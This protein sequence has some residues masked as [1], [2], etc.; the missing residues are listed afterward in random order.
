MT[1]DLKLWTNAARH[2]PWFVALFTVAVLIN[3]A[4]EVAQSP[5]YTETGS[6]LARIGN[7]FL[8]SLIDGVIVLFIFAVGWLALRDALW[9][10]QPGVSGYAL[11]LSTGLAISIGIELVAVNLME[12]W[13][14]SAEMPRLP[15]VGIG[16]R[17]S[18][19]C[20]CFRL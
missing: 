6:M 20:L 3:F 15:V 4:W 2:L 18:P 7:C 1:R 10:E 17:P 12:R 9:F 13:S 11:M 14:Y 16:S 8:A 5:L 19:R